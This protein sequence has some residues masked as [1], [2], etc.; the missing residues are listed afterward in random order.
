M[1]DKYN[2]LHTINVSI[3]K[4][5]CEEGGKLKLAFYAQEND[6]NDEVET[7][8]ED[9]FR[10]YGL[11]PIIEKVYSVIDGIDKY[12]SVIVYSDAADCVS[13]LKRLAATAAFCADIVIAQ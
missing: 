13:M 10:T 4:N 1:R 3:V 5:I 7:I 9:F 12:Q 11:L 2:W 8:L 6:I